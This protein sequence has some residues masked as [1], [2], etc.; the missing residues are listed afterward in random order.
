MGQEY[1][2]KIHKCFYLY[3][4]SRLC[5]KCKY[6]KCHYERC[7]VALLYKRVL[8]FIF[9]FI[10][11][12]LIS[13][14][15]TGEKINKFRSNFSLELNHKSMEAYTV[16]EFVGLSDKGHEN[17]KKIQFPLKKTVYWCWFL[18]LGD[19]FVL[20][21]RMSSVKIRLLGKGT[22]IKPFYGSIQ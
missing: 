8:C 3:A 11:L 4:V 2:R 9:H 12:F 22:G 21:R 14:F 18:L 13:Q 5:V 16:S 19:D 1:E 6:S 20:C 15:L 17:E 7:C 10:V